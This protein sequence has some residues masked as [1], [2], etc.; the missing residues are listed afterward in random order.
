MSTLTILTLSASSPTAISFSMV[1]ILRQGWHHSAQK[2]TRTG[3]SDLRTST[4]KVLSLTGWIAPMRSPSL[5]AFLALQGR[6][7]PLGVEGR[8]AAGAGGGDGLPIGV[9]DD[10]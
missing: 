8:G 4:S 3:I 1:S 9:V 5:K 2:S 7:V 10:V 6:D